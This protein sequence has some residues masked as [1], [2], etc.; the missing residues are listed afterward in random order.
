MGGASEGG[1]DPGGGNGGGALFL[2]SA[3][4]S[5]RGV[6]GAEEVVDEDPEE[7]PPDPELFVLSRDN[8]LGKDPLG[9][10]E[11]TLGGSPPLARL[12]LLEELLG[13]LSPGGSAALTRLPIE[14]EIGISGSEIGPAIEKISENPADPLSSG[15]GDLGG[16]EGGGAS[17]ALGTGEGAGGGNAGLLGGG[18]GLAGGG[19]GRA[20]GGAGREGGGPLGR[21]GFSA[22]GAGLAGGGPGR[23]GGGPGLGG[24]GLAGGK[25]SEPMDGIVISE[26]KT[27][28]YFH[29][30]KRNG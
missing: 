4:N 25:S 7:L 19:P 2:G 1:L 22:G 6:E 26:N 18:A 8:C 3:G 14:S 28:C 16:S 5:R 29:D 9:L 10:V 27:K 21:S 12:L 30:L 20:G 11:G 17:A 13:G 15:E 24:G 23:G